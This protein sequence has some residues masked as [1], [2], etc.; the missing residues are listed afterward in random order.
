[1]K[2]IFS[3][4][5]SQNNTSDFFTAKSSILFPSKTQELLTFLLELSRS[6]ISNMFKTSDALTNKI[7][8]MYHSRENSSL[9]ALELFNGL[10][11]RQLE[12]NVYN[13]DHQEYAQENLVILS[14][15]Y[16]VLRPFDEISP[17]RLDMHDN[18]IDSDNIYKNLYDFWQKEITN[19]FNRT[20]TI[21]NLASA[22]YAKMI[23]PQYHNKV[24][25]CHFLVE[26]DEVRKSIAALAKRERGNI[27][28]YCIKN[29]L[30][31]IQLLKKYSSNGFLFDQQK[32]DEY[33][34]YFIYKK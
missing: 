10:S 27:L 14:A 4:A 20:D 19:Y 26:E 12:L 17:Y 31:N 6:D 16:G 18:L 25:T 15:L 13:S 34:Y 24:V 23:L 11:F 22:E 21:L 7:Y 30:T 29:K 2:I 8:R 28:N 32:S 33:N 9:P 3:P 5:K 1:M